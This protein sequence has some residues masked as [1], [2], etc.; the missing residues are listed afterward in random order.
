MII[1]PY[2]QFSIQL[3][4][5]FIQNKRRAFYIL[6]WNPGYSNFGVHLAWLSSTLFFFSVF[7]ILVPAGLQVPQV[8]D[9]LHSKGEEPLPR[10]CSQH[11]SPTSQRPTVLPS[12]GPKRTLITLLCAMWVRCPTGW[13]VDPRNVCL[14]SDSV[15]SVLKWWVHHSDPPATIEGG[16]KT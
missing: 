6:P 7:A 9:Q 3:C 15:L 13:L 2:Q 4:K 10:V 11:H 8:T 12:W 14:W 1:P 5:I 16:K